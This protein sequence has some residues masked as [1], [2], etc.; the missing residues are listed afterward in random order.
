MRVIN[1]PFGYYLTWHREKN[2]GTEFEPRV[3][4]MD[5]F[6]KVPTTVCDMCTD[7]A[8]RFIFGNFK[9]VRVCGSLPTKKN[10][11]GGSCRGCALA[12]FNN[13]FSTVNR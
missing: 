3:E 8:A 10:P 4:F 13:R 7:R 6:R 12:T 2:R 5:F 9:K 11:R 1:T